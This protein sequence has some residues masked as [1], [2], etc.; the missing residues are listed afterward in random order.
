[1]LGEEIGSN[2]RLAQKL[3]EKSVVWIRDLT[4][5]MF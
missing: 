2:F 5:G 1:M 3:F 4:H